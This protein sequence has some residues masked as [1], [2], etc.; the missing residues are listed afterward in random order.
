MKETLSNKKD[1]IAFFV[2]ILIMLILF[3]PWMN[4]HFATDTYHLI[5][6]GY[7]KAAESSLNDG[8]VLMYV[9]GMIGNFFNLK[10]EKYI[11]TLLVLAFLARSHNNSFNKKNYR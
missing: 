6:M 1:L 2:I 3:F 10:I 9:T 5:D 7:K 8:R 4:G 11:V